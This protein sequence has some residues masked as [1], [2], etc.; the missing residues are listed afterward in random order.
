MDK[1]RSALVTASDLSWRVLVVAAVIALFLVIAVE[2][3]TVVLPTIVALFVTS[4]L[5]PPCNY[6]KRRGLHP[7]LAT[8]VTFLGGLGLLALIVAL[9]APQVASQIEDV[10]ASVQEGLRDIAD[11]LASGPLDISEQELDRYIDQASQQFSENRERIFSGAI[12]GATKA[13]EIVAESLL[14]LVLTFFYLKDGEKMWKWFVSLFNPRN[15]AHA[16]SLGT[17]AWGTIGRFMRGTAIVG[18]VDAALISLAM[19]ILGVPLTAPIAVLTF[20]GAFFPLLGAVFAGFIAVLVALVTEGPLDALLLGAA[21]LAIQQIEGDVLQP[22]VVGKVLGLHPVAIIVTITAGAVIA[23]VPGAF[24][25]VPLASVLAKAA[26][27]MR[28]V[29]EA[30]AATVQQT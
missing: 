21:V 2:L 28:E 10:G 4:V 7:L 1:R 18:L 9:L 11:W 24:L 27:Y 22:I 12:A 15:S 23:G 16:Q 8:W 29:R 13:A 14:V 6:L 30:Q 26:G 19:I 25:A 5:S 20:F 3:R 17:M